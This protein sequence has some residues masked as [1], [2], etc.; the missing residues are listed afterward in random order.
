[1]TY[2]KNPITIKINEFIDNGNWNSGVINEPSTSVYIKADGLGL[3]A[4]KNFSIR[5]IIPPSY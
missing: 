2:S 3:A 5:E 4:Y 1:M